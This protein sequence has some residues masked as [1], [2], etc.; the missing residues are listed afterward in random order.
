MPT[1]PF[2]IGS[3]WIE[4]AHGPG[5]EDGQPIATRLTKL[6][7]QPMARITDPVLVAEVADVAEL[8]AVGA[9]S[10]TVAKRHFK[11]AV[12]WLKENGH[13]D[14][15]AMLRAAHRGQL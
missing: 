2:I 1:K 9:D 7:V 5:A 4:Y 11:R 12:A 14:W 13:A 6:A 3:A 15:R 10:S 8:Y